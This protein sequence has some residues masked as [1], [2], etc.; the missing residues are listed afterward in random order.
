MNDDD[1]FDRCFLLSGS[2]FLYL[3]EKIIKFLNWLTEGK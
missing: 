3:S 1:F 2:I